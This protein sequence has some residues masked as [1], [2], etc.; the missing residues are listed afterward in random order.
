MRVY[1]NTGGLLRATSKAQHLNRKPTRFKLYSERL[2]KAYAKK[3]HPSGVQGG[4][5]LELEPSAAADGLVGPPAGACGGVLHL[6]GARTLERLGQRPHDLYRLDSPGTACKCTACNLATGTSMTGAFQ[7]AQT[8][9]PTCFS[10]ES[11]GFDFL[12]IQPQQ[13]ETKRGTPCAASKQHKHFPVY[14]KTVTQMQKFIENR[15]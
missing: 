8:L 15:Y 6:H 11:T 3:A 4:H 7:T 9:I 14:I 5:Q 13:L 12:I 2:C 10:Y 1:S